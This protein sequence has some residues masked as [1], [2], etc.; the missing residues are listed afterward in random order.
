MGQ[1]SRDT[2]IPQTVV[3]SHR[4]VAK[5]LH[6]SFVSVLRDTRQQELLRL[7][8]DLQSRVVFGEGV[9]RLSSYAHTIVSK[10]DDLISQSNA[11]AAAAIALAPQVDEAI[12]AAEGLQQQCETILC[13]IF[14][15]RPVFLSGDINAL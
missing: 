5:E 2:L 6:A 12:K 14:T 4:A 9:M 13:G 11:A 3:S 7:R 1:S 15:P 8:S 10:R